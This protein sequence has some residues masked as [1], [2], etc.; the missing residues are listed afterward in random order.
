MLQCFFVCLFPFLFRF[1]LVLGF[2]FPHDL[3][4]ETKEIG[5]KCFMKDA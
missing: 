4:K 5:T 3:R 2:C 1:V